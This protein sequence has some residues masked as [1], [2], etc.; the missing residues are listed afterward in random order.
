[1]AAEVNRRTFLKEY[2]NDRLVASVTPSSRFTCRKICRL[3]DFSKDN[4]IV[5]YGPGNGVITK[6][7]L[8]YMNNKSRLIAVETNRNFV[9]HLRK[10]KDARLSV[11]HD[12]AAN[13]RKIMKKTKAD[14]II[15]GI[16]FSY[17]KRDFK[18]KIIK[19][20]AQILKNNGK[21][22]VYQAGPHIEKHLKK[23]FGDVTFRL[24]ALN[25]P[26]LWIYVATK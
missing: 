10:I 17:F 11:R 16:P 4:I 14:Y 23:Y 24:S 22:I 18:D 21:F 12:S 26:P 15:S 8:Y 9:A 1:M 20:T 2:R 3:I 7:L 19:D 6:Y 25:I 5:E 13:I